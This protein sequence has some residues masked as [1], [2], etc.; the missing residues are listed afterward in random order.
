MVGFDELFE[1]EC[2]E[3]VRPQAGCSCAESGADGTG[4]DAV[5][6]QLGLVPDDGDVVGQL[7][8]NGPQM[9]DLPLGLLH[10]LFGPEG[11]AARYVAPFAGDVVLADVGAYFVD[12]LHLEC[13]DL[14]AS[15]EKQRLAVSAILDKSDWGI[16]QG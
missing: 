8:R 12:I 14:G 6:L 2:H 9:G 16:R 5:L 1:G 4:G 13:S 11:A 10:H 3:L 15:V 7:W